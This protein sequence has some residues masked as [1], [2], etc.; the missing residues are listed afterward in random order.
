MFG[1][2][3][4]IKTRRFG[5]LEVGV[6]ESCVWSDAKAILSSYDKRL[7]SGW[8]MPTSEELYFLGEYHLMGIGGFPRYSY[9]SSEESNAIGSKTAVSFVNLSSFYHSSK[10]SFYLLPVRTVSI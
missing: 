6:P 4:K 9:W 10:E 3:K 7:G 1:L 5:N 2:F 8:R